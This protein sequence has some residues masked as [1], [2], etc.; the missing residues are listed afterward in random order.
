MIL[1][2]TTVLPKTKQGEL[3]TVYQLTHYTLYIHISRVRYFNSVSDFDLRSCS[4]SSQGTITDDSGIHSGNTFNTNEKE[5]A[6]SN[7]SSPSIN[8]QYR[9]SEKDYPSSGVFG[10][11]G[12]SQ[13]T[14]RPIRKLPNVP[15][16]NSKQAHIVNLPSLISSSKSVERKSTRTLPSLPT[17]LFSSGSKN[18]QKTDGISS[19]SNIGSNEK[20]TS[21]ASKEIVQSPNNNESGGWIKSTTRLSNFFRSV[22]FSR[23][24]NMYTK[25]VR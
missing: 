25:L 10:G 16:V 6:G 4:S 15:G 9:D 12:R 21:K 11:L 2:E 19:K 8:G 13:A 18:S 1:I 23:F 24:V 5:N 7:N 14:R 20:C 3:T 17:N 22:K